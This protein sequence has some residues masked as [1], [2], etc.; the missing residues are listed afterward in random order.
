LLILATSAEFEVGLLRVR[1]LEGMAVERAKGKLK[2]R[3]PRLSKMQ[4]HE[5]HRM[6][7]VEDH[8]VA[9]LGGVF[10]VSRPTVYR[11]LKRAREDDAKTDV[12]KE[13]SATG[14]LP[15]TP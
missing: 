11:V 14:S 13:W 15:Q 4:Q 3:Q 10:S 5:L 7:D 2:A 1:N 12:L 8:S 6:H 9:D